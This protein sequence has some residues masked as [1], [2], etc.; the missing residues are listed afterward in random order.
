[1]DKY[2][3]EQSSSVMK[4][5]IDVNV[6]DAAIRRLEFIFNEFENIYFSVSF[7]KD[8]SMLIQ[9]AIDVARRMGKL[10]LNVLYVD[11]EAQ[12]EATIAHA[13]RMFARREE[14][15]AFWVC[16][17]ISLRNSVSVYE[18]QWICWDPEQKDIWVRDLPD[19]PGVI[20]DVNYFPFYRYAMEFEDFIIDFS[21]WF[22]NDWEDHKKGKTACG[23]AI[24]TDESLNRFRTLMSDSKI[25]YKGERWTTQVVEDIYNFYPIY[26]WRTEDVWTAVGKNEYDYNKI[27]DAMFIGGVSIHQARLC[28]PYGNDQRRGLEFFQRFEPH[29]WGKIVRRVSGANFGSLYANSFLLGHRK[30]ILP[31]G[32]TWQSYTNFLLDTL[33]RFEAEWFKSKFKVFIKWWEEHRGWKLED[34]FDAIPPKDH[35]AWIRPDGTRYRNLPAWE[36]MAKVIIKN[37]KICKGLTF[38]QSVYLYDKYKEFKELYGV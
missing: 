1:V 38:S 29:T 10:P 26:D 9:L 30:V 4:E 37:D 27:Y 24:R 5:Y 15:N 3:E 36:R 32:H 25:R 18:P 12:Y 35:P 21:K 22:H 13:E 11:F 14:I 17:P 34:F 7:G 28:Q 16:L 2:D 33:P 31:E 6:Y 8:S 19:H 23:V 20:S